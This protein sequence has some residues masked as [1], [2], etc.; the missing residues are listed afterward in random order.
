MLN[1]LISREVCGDL[2]EIQDLLM[3][4]EVGGV[5]DFVF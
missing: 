1:E 3:K 2:L 4:G 5:V